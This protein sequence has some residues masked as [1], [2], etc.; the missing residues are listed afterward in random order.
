ML[1]RSFGRRCLWR[2]TA[3]M[4]SRLPLR[5]HTRGQLQQARHT[6]ASR[7]PRSSAPSPPLR[8][9][10]PAPPKQ[11]RLCAH[12]AKEPLLCALL[13]PFP[14]SPLEFPKIHVKLPTSPGPTSSAAHLCAGGINRAINVNEI[15]ASVLTA[16]T[17][18]DVRINPG[19]WHRLNTPTGPRQPPTRATS[20]AAALGGD[21]CADPSVVWHSPQTVPFLFLLRG[22]C[23][24]PIPPIDHVCARITPNNHSCARF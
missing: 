1:R 10:F 20:F 16:T 21:A 9:R 13:T 11:P 7:P 18:P 24:Q 22:L 15:D 8:D 4:P 12:H 14:R 6:A 2:I 17:L 5:H 19:G 23:V 3:S